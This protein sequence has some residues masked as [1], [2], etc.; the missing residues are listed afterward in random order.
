MIISQNGVMAVVRD[1]GGGQPAASALFAERSESV[2]G[3]APVSKTLLLMISG[4]SVARSITW[5]VM[6][7]QLGSELFAGL[8]ST[9]KG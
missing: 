4:A 8:N 5:Y 7:P 2:A 1:M 6:A 9:V 3:D